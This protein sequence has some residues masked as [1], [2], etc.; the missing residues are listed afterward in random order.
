MLATVG[1]AAIAYLLGS[2]PFGFL[3]GRARGVDL[4]RTGSGN[5]GA[6]NI[7]RVLGLKIALA[8]FALDAGKGL[9]AT[10]L[11]PLAHPQ[12]AGA[13]YLPLICGA[14]AVAGSVASIF[15]GL[16][17]GKGVATGAG[18]F[19][20]LAPLPTAIC[21][22]IW[23]VLVAAFKYVSVG[24]MA[25][26]VAL[27]ALLATFNRTGFTTD[28]VFY[29]GLVVAVLVVARHRTNIRRLAGGTEHRV[30]RSAGAPAQGATR[31]PSNGT[32]HGI[33]AASGTKEDR[34]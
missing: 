23:A 1:S 34:P 4:R 3:V 31:G 27:P 26:A 14:A 6:T 28:P 33:T 24:S 21:L 5:I 15:M 11:I 16:R 9:A 12:G 2:V 18:V 10:R 17:G 29:L 30:A 25:A 32:T 22:G 19:L 13:D 8:V 20:G 7:Y